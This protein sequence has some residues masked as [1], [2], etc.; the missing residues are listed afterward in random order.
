MSAH[1]PRT[2]LATLALLI[3]FSAGLVAAPVGP[4]AAADDPPAVIEMTEALVLGPIG[5]GG[6]SPVRF[7]PIEHAIVTGAWSAPSAGR[8]VADGS[9]GARSWRTVEAD[10]G[11]IA[12]RALRRGWVHWTVEGPAGTVAERTFVLAASGHSTVAVNGVP[13]TGDPYSTG[14][15]E[16]P[17]VLEPGPNHL[18]FRVGRG[19][20]RASLAPMAGG[21]ELAD[22]DPT[23][24]DLVRGEP[25]DAW[26]G[27]PVRRG[28]GA[29]PA[30][31]RIVV[32]DGAEVLGSAPVEGLPPLGV[33]KLPVRIE[34]PAPG[35]GA[36]RLRL[37]V[38]LE[39]GSERL[40]ER[41]RSLRIVEPG[42]LRRRTFLSRIDGSVQPWAH[43]PASAGG[44]GAAAPGIVLTLHGAS[45][46]A[47]RQASC[48]EPRPWA[49][50]VAPMNRRPF[51]FDWE[52]WGR[53]DALEVLDLATSTL[54]VD[55]ARAWLTGH[56]MGGHGTWH[57]GSLHPDRFAAIGPSAGWVSFWSYGGGARF[58]EDD[59]I[60]ELLARA[61]SG[62]DTLGRLE[63]LRELGV[64]VLHGDADRNVP[65]EQARMM[66]AELG[67][68]HTDFAYHERP[69]AGHWWGN[70][71]VDWPPMMDFF[72]RR[73]RP[74]APTV[75]R[76]VF[77]TPAPSMADRM[78]WASVVQ[79]FRSMEPSRIELERVPSGVR[80][81]T[82]NV[83]RLA[84]DAEAFEGDGDVV[85][86]GLDGNA[87]VAP[88]PAKG[89]R[90]DLLRL[91]ETG[92]GW[93]V[94]SPPDATEKTPSREGPFKAGFDHRAILVHG[95]GGTEDDRAWA[96]ARA[97]L[98][99]ETFWYRGNGSFEV[100]ADVDFDPA[101]EPDRSVVFYGHASTNAAWP[102]LLGE[103]PVRVEEGRV[104]AGDRVIEGGD[105]ACALIR[106]R[107]G[108]DVAT[109]AVIAGT[110]P[111]GRRLTDRMPTFVSGV[112][113]PDVLVIEPSM[114]QEGLAGVRG[115]GFFGPDWSI[116]TGTFAW[117][118]DGAG[119]DD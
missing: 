34:G 33:R 89:E 81:T 27:L 9:D 100:V 8:E 28:A 11:W 63:N 71:C 109:V 77:V 13:R 26:L 35:E 115:A 60:G 112:A 20:V 101:A 50:V 103:S 43:V 86:I 54:E 116:E 110:G 1:R 92:G 25:V 38:T 85:T 36:D 18:L 57:L 23:L 113:I 111:A 69:G 119:S 96:L 24:P 2:P 64:Y 29:L 55:P 72:E 6:R 105:L 88:R 7:D 30:G 16:L 39:A 90:V 21:L 42:T 75:D 99:A 67:G 52:D 49:H 3:S 98:D 61:T 73:R 48:Y 78:R 19:R 22:P 84:L 106:P 31:A 83:R 118:S 76:L 102:A 107:P 12:D 44:D 66:R 14:W 87:L 4:G 94:A 108:S 114:L 56:S 93:V 45:V 41:E 40:D 97:R 117:R 95:T 51:G 79:Q 10:G 5:R 104:I 70:Q 59:P 74:E 37:T 68:F 46:P 58:D 15:T 65:V 62:S 47:R 91:D 82:S 32:R 17:V 53:I 80:G